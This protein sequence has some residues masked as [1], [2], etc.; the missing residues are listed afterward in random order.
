M[1]VHMHDLACVFQE[2]RTQGTEGAS[3]NYSCHGEGTEGAST[4]YLYHGEVLLKSRTRMLADPRSGSLD[5]IRA[6]VFVS[7]RHHVAV[8]KN[9]GVLLVVSF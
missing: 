9:W 1:R 2:P 7:S 6:R 3:T 4:N 5:S 8:S